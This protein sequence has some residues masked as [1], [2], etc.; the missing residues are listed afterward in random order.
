MSLSTMIG[1]S[2]F[3]LTI[4]APLLFSG[5]AHAA[6]PMVTYTWTTTSEGFGTHVSAPTSATFEVPLSDVLSGVIDQGDITDIQLTYP[7][8]TFDTSAPSSVGLD[9]QAFVNPATGDFIFH[10]VNQGLAVIAYQANDP[11][12]FLSITV[13]SLPAPPSITVA[14]QFNALNDGSPFAGFPTAGFWTAS[15]PTIAGAA[16]EPAAWATMLL[17]VGVAGAVLRRR[18]SLAPTAA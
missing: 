18:K 7:G 17:G 10:D 1:K 12:T 2:L 9:A 8:L 4:S 13:D 16:P 5:L 14:D 11:N 6:G 3:G 15:L